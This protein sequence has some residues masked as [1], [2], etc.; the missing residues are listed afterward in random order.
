MTDSPPAHSFVARLRVRHYEMDALGHV[1]NAVYLHYLEQ[2]AWEHS[3]S[4]GVTLNRY[5]ALGGVFIMRRLEIDYLHPVVAGDPLEI[6]TWVHEMHGAR[7]YRKYQITNTR[8]GQVAARATALWAWIERASG[9]PRPIPP[10]LIAIF[11]GAEG[12]GNRGDG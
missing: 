4:L 1:N 9:R 10:E 8:S 12:T 2:A 7:A 11:A 6:A 5:A 3:E